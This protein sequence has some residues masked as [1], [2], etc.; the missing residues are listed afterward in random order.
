MLNPCRYHKKQTTFWNSPRVTPRPNA[1]DTSHR[2]GLEQPWKGAIRLNGQINMQVCRRVPKRRA[3]EGIIKKIGTIGQH[4]YEK[5]V[6]VTPSKLRRAQRGN[7]TRPTHRAC[8]ITH[9]TKHPNV[10]KK[11]RSA[12]LKKTTETG[13]EPVTVRRRISL[14]TAP[15]LTSEAPQGL[16][17]LANINTEHRP[18]QTASPK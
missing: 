12:K 5:G 17:K 4:I 7:V 3:M 14:L 6:D 1:W 16:N 8:D 9:P 13:L 15:N 18:A 11:I 10:K 2:V